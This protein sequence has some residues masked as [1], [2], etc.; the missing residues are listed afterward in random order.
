MTPEETTDPIVFILRR[1]TDCDRCHGEL[2]KGRFVCLTG[3]EALCLKCAGLAHLEFLPS[4]DAA[5]TRRATKYSSV[6]VVVMKK[7][8]ARRRSERQGILAEPEAIRRAEEES[9]ADAD[10]RAKH[11]EREAT[12]REAADRKYIARF[13]EAIRAQYPGCPE[14]E[15][16]QIA[17]HACEKYSGRVGRAAFAKQ[18]DPAAVHLAVIAHIRHEHTHYDSLVA[19][20]NDKHLARSEVQP[21]IDRVLARWEPPEPEYPE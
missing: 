20:H 13:A 7:S 6:H 2:G 11:R 16:D 10:R 12:R 19:R 17:Q 1:D 9:L 8:P 21:K 3:G 4:G 15:A 14:K 5:V 18:L